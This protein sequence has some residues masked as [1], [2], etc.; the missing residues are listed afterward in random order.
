MLS[1]NMTRTT[2]SWMLFLIACTAIGQTGQPKGA[3]T[4]EAV[5]E[6]ARNYT[7]SLPNYTCTLTT[8]EVI[9]P[10]NA[11]N[12]TPPRMINVVE[13]FSF[14]NGKEL[15]KILKRDGD[16]VKME[17]V[18]DRGGLSQG[19]FAS[20]LA[21]VFEPSAGADLRWD[22]AATL[23]GRKVDVIAFHVPQA[24]GYLIKQAKGDLHVPFEGFVYADA[25]T[26]AVLRI[27]MKCVM[28]PE[29]SD[30]K[31]LDLTLDYKAAQVG[32]QEFILPSQ[33]VLRFL[34]Y[35]EDRQHTNEGRYSAYH[36]FSSDATLQFDGDKK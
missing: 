20:L 14:V 33:F 3:D 36:R 35:R 2:N 9:T 5:R 8:N 6:Y 15:R 27:Q 31:R 18:G 17:T 22:R 24:R 21:I 34:D 28:I 29:T 16:S 23:N 30:I 10:P 4:I 1:A 13:E 25:Q 12:P 32:G 11:G 7:R 26:H 19:E